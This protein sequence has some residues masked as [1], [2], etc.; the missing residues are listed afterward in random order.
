[1]YTNKQRLFYGIGWCLICFIVGGIFTY[2]E[3]RI[4]AYISFAFGL[5]SLI[6]IKKR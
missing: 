4:L 6:A 2:I 5:M 1:M 3:R